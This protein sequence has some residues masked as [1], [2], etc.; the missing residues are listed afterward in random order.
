[1]ALSRFSGFLCE[2]S[3]LKSGR[4]F[5]ARRKISFSKLFN[6]KSYPVKPEMPVKLELRDTLMIIDISSRIINK[7]HNRRDY[8]KPHTYHAQNP[9]GVRGF[10][11]GDKISLYLGVPRFRSKIYCD[12]PDYYRRAA[13]TTTGKRSY[14]NNYRM[15]EIV[16]DARSR[17]YRRLLINRLL[18][19]ACLLESAL[20]RL[21]LRG[22]RRDLLRCLL[23]RN[24]YRL[25][26]RRLTGFSFRFRDRRELLDCR[27]T[28][29]AKPCIIL[30]PGSTSWTKHQVS[31]GF[32]FTIDK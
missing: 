11:S 28:V 25:L 19:I 23:R 10:L 5:D 32:S 16:I 4:L 20:L 8:K 14:R 7:H 17:R 30:V 6:I 13:E 15:R 21:I 29:Y 3:G 12:Y 31:P 2:K 26:R 9:R 24:N 27:P 1:L 18:L 22:W